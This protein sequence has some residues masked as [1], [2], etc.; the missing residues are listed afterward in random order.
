MIALT[1]ERAT[2]PERRPEMATKTPNSARIPE[3]YQEL[4]GSERRPRANAKFMGP[5]DAGE[6]L[7][8]TIVLRRRPDGPPVPSFDFYLST[9]PARRRRLSAED[10]APKY[11]A[12]ADDIAKVE[13]FARQ[14]GLTVVDTHPAR[15]TVV[16]SGTVGQMSDAFA[17]ELGRYEHTVARGGRDKPQKET[18]RGRNGFIH[19]PRALAD[20]I[21]GVFGLDNRRIS[22]RTRVPGDP[23]NTHPMSVDQ[24]RSLYNFPTNS[25][26]GQA[27]A[28]FS[29]GGYQQRDIIK[30]F[31]PASPPSIV[32]VDVDA[33]N[34]G[35]ADLE[36][37]MDICIAGLAAPG[38]K[39]AVYFTTHDQRGW[40]DLLG[41]AV[42]PHPIDPVCSV[43]SSS[44]FFSNGDDDDQMYTEGIALAWLVAVNL[45]LEDAA[46]QGVTFCTASGDYGVD[47][48]AHTPTPDGDIE[49][50]RRAHVIYP[51]S[52]PW[53][54]SCGGTTIGNI[55]G[56]S[57]DEYVWKDSNNAGGFL[58]QAQ[59][60]G[61]GVSDRFPLPSYQT[62]AGIPVSINDGHV[63]RGVPDVAANAS[64]NSGY[65]F[66]LGGQ[67][68]ISGGTSA[69]APLWAGLIAVIN[70]AFGENLGFINPALYALGSGYFRDITGA[71][72]PTDNGLNGVA[73]YPAGP[74]WDAC[75]GW[76]S[77]DGVAL[78]CGLTGLHD[79]HAQRG[80][81]RFYQLVAK[82][83]GGIINDGGGIEIFG[84]HIVH[85][86]PGGPAEFDVLLA[87]ATQKL[88]SLVSSKQGAPLRSAMSLVLRVAKRELERLER[89]ETEK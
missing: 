84:R 87:D 60:T 12:S 66:Y 41:R 18:Y 72:G 10:F 31:S 79:I 53:A 14:H 43:I 2:T 48:S 4:E 20:V 23:P 39:I 56:S 22:K 3:S 30:T 38:A 16:V 13:A 6:H 82:I 78:L 9:P 61:G 74:G 33:S 54:L 7:S 69:A 59:A 29:E 40:V 5:A 88:T 46:L 65:P 15:R 27:I 58:S 80:S 11:G 83:L 21:V 71:P 35:A 34:S 50:D 85:V 64:P 24:V 62:D 26:A 75:T 42:H 76:G 47:T 52:D 45:A 19:A 86:A 28:I 32:D 44:Y 37:T 55:N 8:V 17:V 63:G 57:F 77:P 67:P 81:P 89:Q 49:D 1:S 25:A 73:G 70:A 51:G 36:T 68:V